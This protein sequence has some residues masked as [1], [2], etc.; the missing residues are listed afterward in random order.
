VVAIAGAASTSFGQGHDPAELVP[1]ATDRA[2]ADAGIGRADVD[3]LVVAN[4]AGEAFTDDANVSVWTATRAGLAGTGTIR[5]DTGPSS[6]L[7]ALQT[8]RGWMR[9]PGVDHVLV[10]G[11]EAMTTVPTAEATDILAG[12]MADDERAAGLSLPAL[13]AMLT[14]AYLHRHDVDAAQLDRVARKAHALAEANPIAQFGAL[15]ADE[16]AGS[17]TVAPPLKLHHCA[18]LT[19]GA[20]GLVLADESPVRVD[21]MGA[22]TDKLGYTQRRTPPQR[23]AATQQ[24]AD[25][26]FQQAGFDREAVDVVE[27]HDAF[28]SLEAINL[29]DLGFADEGEGFARLPGPEDPLASDPVVNP[30]GGLKARGHP[31]GATGLAQLTEAVDQLTGRAANQAPDATRALVHSI[32]GFGNNVHVA[33]LEGAR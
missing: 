29:E 17:R 13:V 9:D 19:D 2:L 7:A 23:F 11:W 1:E 31:V 5:V 3:R 26:A 27:L 22:A 16:L 24:A 6:G 20:A 25:Q 33:L 10:L 28:V 4:A 21:A 15:D 14:R 30:S 32:G 12:L 18:P 8:A